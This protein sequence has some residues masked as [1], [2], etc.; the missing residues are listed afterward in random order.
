MACSEVASCEGHAPGIQVPVAA[1][2][3]PGDRTRV[4]ELSLASGDGACSDTYC[5]SVGSRDSAEVSSWRTRCQGVA[6]PWR[7]SG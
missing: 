4:G 7:A 5:L 1:D 3:L 6:R 2:P